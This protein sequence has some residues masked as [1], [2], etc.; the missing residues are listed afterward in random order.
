MA[1]RKEKAS[2]LDGKEDKGRVSV[3]QVKV[4]GPEEELESR[5]E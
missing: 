2:R 1:E 4:V 5:E 3:R